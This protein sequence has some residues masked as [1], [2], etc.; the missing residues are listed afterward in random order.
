MKV[1]REKKEKREAIPKEEEQGNLKKHRIIWLKKREE[2]HKDY[3]HQVIR[4][5]F[6]CFR[7]P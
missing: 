3:E 1:G 4:S 6:F 5:N 2:K 7:I